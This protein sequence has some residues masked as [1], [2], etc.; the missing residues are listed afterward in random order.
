MHKK[1]YWLILASHFSVCLAMLFPVIRVSETRLSNLGITLEYTNF[2]NL[3]H[4]ISNDIYTITAILM[5]LLTIGSAFGVANAIWGI[6]SKELK[7]RT[8][9][10]SFALSFTLA[11]MGALTVYSRSY[12]LFTICAAAFFTSAI[13]SIRLARLEQ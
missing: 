13:S 9:K 12:V 8:S 10:L 4:Y 1:Y 2:I 11:A 3:F 6:A 7:P 5:L